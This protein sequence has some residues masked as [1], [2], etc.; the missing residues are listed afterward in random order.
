MVST[1]RPAAADG[2]ETVLHEF[3]FQTSN[4]PDS[5]PTAPGGVWTA[6]GGVHTAPGG[7]QTVFSRTTDQYH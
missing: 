4:L 7:V 5:I 2:I 1:L 6:L 3:E